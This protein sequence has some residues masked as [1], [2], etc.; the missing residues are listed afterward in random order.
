M[1]TWQENGDCLEK[2]TKLKQ[3]HCT[4]NE[5]LPMCFGLKNKKYKLEKQC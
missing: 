3:T 4:S 1:L 5:S 2:L